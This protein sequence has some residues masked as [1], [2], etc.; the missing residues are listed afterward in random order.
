MRETSVSYVRMGDTPSVADRGV[1]GYV[2]GVVKVVG[3]PTA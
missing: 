3:S 1:F 2:V